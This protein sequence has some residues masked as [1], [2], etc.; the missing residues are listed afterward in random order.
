MFP[1]EDKRD[2]CWGLDFDG[3]HPSLRSSV[4]MILVSPNKETILFSYRLEFNCTN[5]VFD[6]EALI[7]DVN[8]AIDMNIKSLHV[9]G[10]S[11][12]I[13]SQINR[14]FAAKNPRLKQYRDVFWDVMKKLMNFRLKLYLE[15][16]II[17]KTTLQF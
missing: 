3:A 4:G 6:Y 16:R 2:G 12:L 10:V 7:L 13:V 17:Q 9:I 5:N 11:D 8:L 15:K 14:N 1:D